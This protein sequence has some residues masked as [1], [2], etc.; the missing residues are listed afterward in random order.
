MDLWT[1]ARE[2]SDVLTLS[3]L[4]SPRDI[5]QSLA[6][7]AALAEAVAF[8]KGLGVT[9]VYLES[10]RHGR[11]TDADSLR[12]VRDAFASAG[13]ASAGGVTTTGL[14][15]VSTGWDMA[16]CFTDPG[17]RETLQRAF[18]HAAAC[19]DEVMID[20]FYF[21]DCQC[22]DCA[23]ACEGRDWGAYRRDLLTRLADERILAPARRVNP[24]V[25]IT[26]KYPQWYDLWHIR[27]YDPARQIGLFDRIWAGTETRTPDRPPD[28]LPVVPQYEAW[29]VLRWLIA[30]AGSQCGGGWFDTFRTDPTTYV[31]QARQTVLAG[32]REAV[33]FAYRSLQRDTGPACCEA[34]RAELPGL[35]DLA[36]A[37]SGK[38][39]VGI[40]AVKPPGSEGGEDRYAFDYLGMLGLPL[41]PSPSL[42]ADA[43]AALVTDHLFAQPDSV[44]RLVELH[45]RGAPLLATASG[46]RRLG[47]TAP[48]VEPAHVLPPRTGQ[49]EAF[50][51]P[52][53]R[54][55]AIRRAMLA[56]LG[57]SFDAPP[58]VAIYPFRDGPVAV[59]SFLNRPATVELIWPGLGGEVSLTLPDGLAD[60]PCRRGEAVELT[61]PPRS[62]ALVE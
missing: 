4:I 22:D 24:D 25:R 44:E 56:P 12:R 55:E 32:A 35:L 46:A 38:A 49:R 15:K 18:E 5:N 11:F 39:P 43:P 8:C 31:E 7:P 16:C 34:F 33:L 62:L 2:S 61:L 20:D 58:G 48:G 3:T 57:G 6:D 47:E 45:N 41:V 14:G 21:T 30:S 10:F 19:F 50:E 29:V 42:R 36:R 59:E 60:G 23:A 53:R 37:V 9:K 13:L 27:G 40:E 52:P 26:L 54:L 51:L 1:R 28:E 17:T